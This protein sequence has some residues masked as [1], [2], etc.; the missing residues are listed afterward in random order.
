MSIARPGPPKPSGTEVQLQKG[1]TQVYYDQQNILD[2]AASITVTR[3]SVNV[4]R[5]KSGVGQPIT[6]QFT[7][8]STF[9]A[10]G[11]ATLNVAL[12][13]D[14]NEDLST[15][16]VIQDLAAPIQ[17]ADLVTGFNFSLKVASEFF[18]GFI[19]LLYTVAN[20]P[21]TAGTLTAAVVPSVQNWTP[22]AR[23]YIVP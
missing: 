4:M 2:E 18:E 17:V 12:I 14:D 1:E 6:I 10:A 11:P 7:V 21:M 16:T 3:R 20:G 15:P 19:G 22:Y 5:Y 8:N 23:N 13:T 9:A